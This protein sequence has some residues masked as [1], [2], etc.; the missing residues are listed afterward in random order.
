MS[1]FK[2][3]KAQSPGVFAQSGQ[4]GNAL[5]SGQYAIGITTDDETW[6]QESTG[7]PVSVQAPSEGS[8]VNHDENMMASD[9]PNP[10]GAV[11]F[12]TF[13]ASAAGGEASAKATFDY[14][15][16]PGVPAFPSGRAALNSISLLKENDKQEAADKTALTNQIVAAVGMS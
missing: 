7:A 13:L 12:L 6:T 4:L 11:A 16:L 8:G 15:P 3:L 14:S 10:K 1:W 5:V 2:Q 9:G